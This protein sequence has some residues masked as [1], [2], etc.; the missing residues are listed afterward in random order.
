MMDK[1]EIKLV[2]MLG[3]TLLERLLGSVYF[4]PAKAFFMY[5]NPNKIAYILQAAVL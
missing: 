2:Q 1:I 3:D 5:Y 4:P